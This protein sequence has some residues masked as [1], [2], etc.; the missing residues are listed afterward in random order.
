MI[1][2]GGY[3]MGK[4]KTVGMSKHPLRMTYIHMVYRCCLPTDKAWKYYGGRGISVCKEWLD[5]I[6]VFFD[7]ALPL[8]EDGLQIDRIN[9]DGNYEPSNC[10]FVT[11]QENIRNGSHFI[12]QGVR[13]EIVKDYQFG[14]SITRIAK[15][16]NVSRPT[17]YSILK[18]NKII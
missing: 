16:R 14:L 3:K 1:N 17:I 13:E 9:N 4:T 10:R 12:K 18:E 5:D 2:K 7:W 15:K 11:P 6:N 8:W